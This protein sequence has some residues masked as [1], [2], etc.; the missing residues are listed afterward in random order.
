[1]SRADAIKLDNATNKVDRLRRYR[2]RQR[3]RGLC[4]NCPTPSGGRL[5]CPSCS[6][7][8]ATQHRATRRY[9][10]SL[11]IVRELGLDIQTHKERV[12]ADR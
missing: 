11:P 4:I 12:N 6:A 7:K 8:N 9:G 3:K 1:M 2:E 5:R 10:L